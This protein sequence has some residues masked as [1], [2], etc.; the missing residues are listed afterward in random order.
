MRALESAGPP[1]GEGWVEV[2]MSVEA[3]AV[4]VSD[5]LRLG[6][7]AEALGPAGLRRAVAGAVAVLAERYAVGF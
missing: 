5:L 3:E 2:E 1:D 4:A 7:E 6:T